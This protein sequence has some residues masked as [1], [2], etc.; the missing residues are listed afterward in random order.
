MEVILRNNL[1]ESVRAGDRVIFVGTLI[2]VPDVAAISAPGEKAEA[3]PGTPHN[4]CSRIF[5]S[6]WLA[7]ARHNRADGGLGLPLHDERVHGDALKPQRY[8]HIG[9][10]ASFPLASPGSLS[11]SGRHLVA[12]AQ[13]TTHP[14]RSIRAGRR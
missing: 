13:N 7:R 10:P 9:G 12:V 1:V 2:V 6:E 8:R 5:V 4:A 14:T 11:H 3:R